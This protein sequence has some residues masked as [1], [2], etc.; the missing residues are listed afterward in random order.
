MAKVRV[1]LKGATKVRSSRRAPM[2]KD[3][4]TYK[5]VLHNEGADRSAPGMTAKNLAEYVRSKGIE[6]HLVWNPY[7]GEVAQLLPATDAARSMLNGGVYNGV[8]NNRRGKICLQV[9]IVN[10]GGKPFTDS[11]MKGVEKIV[12]FADQLGVPRKA[13]SSWG[14]NAGRGVEQF[15]KS[16]WHGHCH[17][18]G[19]D[20]IDP[21]KINI[22][23][24]F[25]LADKRIAAQKKARKAKK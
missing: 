12:A 2:A 23:K 22:K 15:D 3:A 1:W 18:P 7:T 19:N 25:A 13:R 6:Y 9:C 14:A 16:G 20:H 17:S 24:M 11:P 21:A 10:F 4:N 5:V 8:G